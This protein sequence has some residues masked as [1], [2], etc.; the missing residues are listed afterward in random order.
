M[1][2]LALRP[3]AASERY[4]PADETRIDRVE[5]LEDMAAAE[6]HWRALEQGNALASAYQRYDF[7]KLWQHHVGA[8]AGIAPII[9]IGFNRRGLPLFLWPL[10]RRPVAGWRLIEFLGGKHVNFNMA[11][12]R[13]DLAGQID[14]ETLRGL[15][16]KLSAHGDVVSLANQ[17]LTWGGATNPFGLLPNQAAV[18]TGFSGA[19]VADYDALLR[20][21]SNSSTRKKMRKKERALSA[22]G[23]VRFEQ[24]REPEDVRRVLDIFF[25]QKSVRMRQQGVQDAFG[26]PDVR[27]FLE[28]AAAERLPD[29]APLIELYA[30]SV[31][32][33]VVATF[34]GMT[35]GNRFSG[36]FNSIARDRYVAESPG[37]QLLGHLVRHCC[38][39]GLGTFDLGIGRASYKTLYCPDAEPLFDNHLALTRAGLPLA[40]ALKVRAK[41]K[42]AMKQHTLPW[43]LVQASRRLRARFASPPS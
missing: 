40:V 17:P 27:R 35:A 14:V 34:G 29:G 2:V 31:G 11:L 25:K 3:L 39:R 32:E 36:M 5:I 20:A 38:E 22:H 30:L 23:I 13:R 8:P 6:P 33:I 9:V 18:D 16:A 15:L 12:W 43:R 7:L 10:G 19:L 28:A 24:V 4:S 26:K 1:N 37:E 42:R 21:R 41:V